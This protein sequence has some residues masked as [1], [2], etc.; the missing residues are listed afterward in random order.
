MDFT[1]MRH[2]IYADTPTTPLTATEEKEMIQR[3]HQGDMDARRRLIECNLRFVIKMALNFR[4]QGLSLADLIQ[5]GNL[6]L[7]EADR[8]S[9]V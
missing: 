7:I 3:F 1:L 6:G 8:K 5:E 4:N 9:V 2:Q